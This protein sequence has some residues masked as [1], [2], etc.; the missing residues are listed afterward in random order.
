MIVRY[1]QNE[2]TINAACNIYETK[3]ITGQIEFQVE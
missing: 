1:L 3:D 2:I